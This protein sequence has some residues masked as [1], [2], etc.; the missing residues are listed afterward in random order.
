MVILQVMSCI[1]YGGT[2]A[3]VYNQS[4]E[5]L[6]KHPGDQILLLI[7][8]SYVNEQRKQEFEELGI[9]IFMS[10]V[11][12]IGNGGAIRRDL[13]Q[14]LQ[15]QKID[16]IHCH[17]NLGSFI[18]IHEAK[19]L[20]IPVRIAH[21]HDTKGFSENIIRRMEQKI[22]AGWMAH[23]A[24]ALAACSKDAGIYLFGNAFEKKGSVIPNGIEV[25]KYDVI[26][27]TAVYKLKEKYRLCGKYVIG[28]I[29]RFEEKKNQK[30]LID[31]FKEVSARVEDAVLVLG[32]VDAG[33]EQEIKDYVKEAGL[34]EQVR[35]VGIRK[36][37]P[38]W[39]HLF[40]IWV[41]PS[42]FEGLGIVLLEA[43]FCGLHCLASDQ[44]SRE[45]DMGYGLIQFLPL[46]Q[47]DIWVN[48]ILEQYQNTE[49]MAETERRER[50]KKSAYNIS[51]SA[52]ELYSLY[53][54]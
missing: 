37:M 53:T 48:K 1:E 31:C 51:N 47:K 35:F 50:N 28:N 6:K 33:M 30:F 15:Q 9:P 42:L 26:N 11:P 20:K 21:S 36:D 27:E 32:G 39:M 52:K 23:E 10:R 4:R 18:V 46:T 29:T 13:Q 25:D 14:I 45:A 44:V 12:G 7:C 40:D 43:Q 24:T 41:M 49:R 38:D 5:I 54:R 17:M 3:F 16:V 19:R 2:E 22:R 34:E 8:G